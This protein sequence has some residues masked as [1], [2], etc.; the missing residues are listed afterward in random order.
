MLYPAVMTQEVAWKGDYCLNAE[1]RRNGHMLH[2]GVSS[3]PRCSIVAPWMP[4]VLGSASEWSVESSG[5]GKAKG[6]TV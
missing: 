3:L 2:R 5:E 6:P 1:M 4:L